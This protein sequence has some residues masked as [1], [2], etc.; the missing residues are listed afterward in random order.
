MER[1]REGRQMDR[2]GGQR[3]IEQDIQHNNAQKDNVV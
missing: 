2:E 3:E 1:G